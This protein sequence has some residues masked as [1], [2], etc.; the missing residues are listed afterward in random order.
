MLGGQRCV[1]KEFIQFCLILVRLRAKETV[2]TTCILQ[3][4][5]EKDNDPEER[6]RGFASSDNYSDGLQRCVARRLEASDRVTRHCA[7]HRLSR[8]FH[9]G[10]VRGSRNAGRCRRRGIPG[11]TPLVWRSAACAPR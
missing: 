7:H 8:E 3:I 6:I 1:T 5:A 4:K 10:L 2:L 9:D 11:G